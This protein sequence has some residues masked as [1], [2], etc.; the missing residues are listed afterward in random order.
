VGT[1]VVRVTITKGKSAWA[2]DIEAAVVFTDDAGLA[3]LL[4]EVLPP[5]G[6]TV[7]IK[8]LPTHDETET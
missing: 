5:H 2:K 6:Y 4:K 3:A 1:P 7:K 8:K